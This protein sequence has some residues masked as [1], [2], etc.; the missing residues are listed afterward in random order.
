MWLRNLDIFSKVCLWKALLKPAACQ[1]FPRPAPPAILHIINS[2]Q[3]HSP[4][5]GKEMR[6]RGK[7]LEVEGKR[8]GGSSLSSILSVSCSLPCSGF[9]LLAERWKHF[10]WKQ[11]L[12]KKAE[13]K[14]R[15]SSQN[16]LFELSF[17]LCTVYIQMMTR[18]LNNSPIC[19]RLGSSRDA[20]SHKY[21]LLPRCASS[22]SYSVMHTHKT[23][24]KMSNLYSKHWQK[25]NLVTKNK[26]G[27]EWRFPLRKV[28]KKLN[29]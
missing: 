2:W 8:R 20:Y 19:E 27:V 3:W 17:G 1:A 15:Y 23:L 5:G 18:S 12:Y 25:V 24:L 16:V 21:R 26:K 9:K 4:G 14:N 13:G 11:L 22:R 10:F 7:L 6:E 28:K 29:K